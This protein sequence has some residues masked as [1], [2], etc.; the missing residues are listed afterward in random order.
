MKPGVLAS[1]ANDGHICV[2][3]VGG[4]IDPEHGNQM[5]PELTIESAHQGLSVEDVCWSHFDENLL[6]SVGDDKALSVWDCRQPQA[7]CSQA[8][9][10]HA[11]DAMTVDASPFDPHLLVSGGNDGSVNLWDNRNLSQALHNLGSH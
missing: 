4:G 11:E 6:I 10:S 2:W 7:P 1:G 8:A 3:N 5:K 9:K